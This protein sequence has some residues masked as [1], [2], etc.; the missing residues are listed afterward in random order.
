[1]EVQIPCPY[2]AEAG[3]ACM[4][5]VDLPG[6]LRNTFKG[7]PDDLHEEVVASLAAYTVRNCSKC[8]EDYTIEYEPA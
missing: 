6:R 7:T 2:A 1:M 5:P 8:D 4:D 3:A